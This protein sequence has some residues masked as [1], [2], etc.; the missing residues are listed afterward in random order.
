MR[1]IDRKT[2][3]ACVVPGVRAAPTGRVLLVRSVASVT[4]VDHLVEE[5]REHFVTLL[6]AGDAAHRVDKRVPGVVHA[7]LDAL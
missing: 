4:P 1:E 5:R 3:C 2:Q 6:V 7:S